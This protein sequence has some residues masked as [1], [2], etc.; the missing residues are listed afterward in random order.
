M[1][2]FWGTIQMLA[3]IHSGV[4]YRRG[5]RILGSSLWK[6]ACSFPGQNASS[7]K[8]LAADKTEKRPGSGVVRA[9]PSSHTARMCRDAQDPCA[10]SSSKAMQSKPQTEVQ[11]HGRSPGPVTP[12]SVSHSCGI[13]HTARTAIDIEEKPGP[14]CCSL[15]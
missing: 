2:A 4:H 6:Q 11:L 7:I 14:L 13:A 8:C 12:G 1:Y 5:A 10:L 15:H 3:Y 9:L